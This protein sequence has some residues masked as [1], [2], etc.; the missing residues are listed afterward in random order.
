MSDV[1]LND[2]YRLDERLATGGMG[3]GWRAPDTF[4]DRQ[5]AVKLLRQEY[6]SD[7][8]ALARFQAEARFAAAVQ[9]GG[10]AQMYDYG[11]HDDRAYL[12]MELVPGEPL[13]KILRRVERLDA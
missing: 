7:A 1:V 10:I 4:L 3:E 13:S 9:H 11:E 8:A 5:V 2:R 6:V 12:V